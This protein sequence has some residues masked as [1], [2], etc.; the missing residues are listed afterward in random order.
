VIEIITIPTA[1]AVVLATAIIIAEDAEEVEEAAVGAVGEPTI[2]NIYKISNV[3]IVARKVT[4][5]LT[6]PSQEKRTINSQTW[7]PRRIS[8]TCFNPL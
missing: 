7:F 8:K 4:T 2:V 5:P 1:G 6:V 3:L